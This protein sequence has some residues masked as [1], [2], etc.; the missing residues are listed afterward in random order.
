M[1]YMHEKGYTGYRKA[2]GTISHTAADV[3][4]GEPVGDTQP[5][6]D[7]KVAYCGACAYPVKAVGS[8]RIDYLVR[9]YALVEQVVVALKGRTP[10][11]AVADW[12][13]DNLDVSRVIGW[14]P[15]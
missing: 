11:Q 14:E 7:G 6:I 9:R 15:W 2:T 1:K 12:Q 10:L 13:A 4:R 8:I 3:W 5:D